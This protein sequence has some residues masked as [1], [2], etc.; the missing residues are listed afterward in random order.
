MSRTNLMVLSASFHCAGATL[1]ALLPRCYYVLRFN[2]AS[3]PW[4]YRYVNFEQSQNKCREL[5]VIPLHTRFYY[6]LN[7]LL[8]CCSVCYDSRRF[9][10]ILKRRRCTVQLK[11]VLRY[12]LSLF[13]HTFRG[14]CWSRCRPFAIRPT[15]H[16]SAEIIS[17]VTSY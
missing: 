12:L 14:A 17:S 13:I 11:R 3:N 16:N 2:Y 9:G 7:A 10:Q 5:V 6:D 15:F 8:S 1:L 4:R